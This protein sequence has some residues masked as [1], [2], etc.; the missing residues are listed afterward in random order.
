MGQ[1]AL[2][3]LSRGDLA[4]LRTAFNVLPSSIR[5]ILRLSPTSP[6]KPIFSDSPVRDEISGGRMRTSD[7]SHANK[8][9]ERCEMTKNVVVY[10]QHG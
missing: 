9:I 5:V 1:S 4:P 6:P 10:P 2:I 3:N 8:T 7:C